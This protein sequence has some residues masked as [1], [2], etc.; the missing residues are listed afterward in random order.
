MTSI[1]VVRMNSLAALLA[2]G[3][4]TLTA[5]AAFAADCRTSAKVSE[6][7]DPAKNT[8]MGGHLAQHIFGNKKLPKD[9]TYKDKSVFKTKADFQTTWKQ[10]LALDKKTTSAFNAQNCAKLDGEGQTVTVAMLTRNKQE[11]IKGYSCQDATCSQKNELDFTKVG[12]FY[13]F[14]GSEAKSDK[15]KDKKAKAK[16]NWILVTAYP[17]N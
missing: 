3:V 10:Y 7:A 12:F 8:G 11:K 17:T 9:M 14:V 5:P 13:R 1:A 2:L 6:S 16:G 15:K 4:A